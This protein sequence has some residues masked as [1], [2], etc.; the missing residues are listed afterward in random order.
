[1]N[2]RYST[3]IISS[4]IL[5]SNL[6]TQETKSQ[7]WNNHKAAVALTYDD[8]LNVHLDKVIPVLDSLHFKGTFYIP[9]NAAAFDSRLEDWR[10]IACNGHEL[11]NHTLFHP[12]AGKPKGREWVSPDHDLDNYSVT[13]ILDEIK[14]NNTLLKAID[15]KNLRT[16]AYTCGDMSVG[17]SDFSKLIKDDFAGARGVS[18]QFEKINTIDLLNIKAFFVT[19][20]TGDEL[21]N[22]AKQAIEED[23]LIVFLFHGVGGEHSINI[24]LSEHNKLVNFLKTNEKDFWVAPLVEISTFVSNNR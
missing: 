18:F 1:M 21:I 3:I 14:L 2:L 4:L 13:Q 15:G 22:L 24:P 23:A 10:H 6:S 5:F 7:V 9:G 12:C 19:N 11:G 16:F 17:D 20:Q 8:A